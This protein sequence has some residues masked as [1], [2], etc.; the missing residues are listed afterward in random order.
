MATHKKNSHNLGFLNYPIF[1]IYA[2][3]QQWIQPPYRTRLSKYNNYWQ[4]KERNKS[5]L[6]AFCFQV[7]CKDLLWTRNSSQATMHLASHYKPL[8]LHHSYIPLIY[9]KYV[10]HRRKANRQDKINYV[11]FKIFCNL[12][13]FF[14]Q[15]YNYQ[16]LQQNINFHGRSVN[17]RAQEDQFIPV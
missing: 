2:I 12:I 17:N 13:H 11:L 15:K 7:S 4:T 1:K 8:I 6:K 3:C 10:T 5:F 9:K 14:L 16:I